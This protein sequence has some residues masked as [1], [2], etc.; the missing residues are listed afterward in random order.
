MAQNK[1]D[2]S[3]KKIFPEAV[4]PEKNNSS[5]KGRR[6]KKVQEVVLDD[7]MMVS[8]SHPLTVAS[9]FNITL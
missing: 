1:R 8:Q 7:V 3:A 9:P 4:V 2:L 5:R 6:A